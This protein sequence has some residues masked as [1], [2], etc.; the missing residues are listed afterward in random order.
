MLCV[1]VVVAIHIVG[2]LLCFSQVTLVSRCHPESNRHHCPEV[3]RYCERSLYGVAQAQIPRSD[4]SL[5][6]LSAFSAAKAMASSAVCE[7]I[8][9]PSEYLPQ[10]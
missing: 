5:S 3:L 9:A 2:Y 4:R 7:L 8:L 10:E 6:A 1:Y